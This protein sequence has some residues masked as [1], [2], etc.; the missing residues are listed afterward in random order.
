[1]DN[2]EYSIYTPPAQP[3]MLKAWRVTEGLLHAMRNEVQAHGAQFRIVTL[4]N[5]PQVM[6]DIAKRSELEQKLSVKDLDYADRRI[7]EFG[8][9]VGVPV[10]NLAPALSAYAEEHH[11]YLN[12]FTAT[13]LGSGHWN[14]TGHRLA[15]E[16]IAMDLCPGVE[17]STAVRTGAL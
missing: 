2:L 8:V 9:L 11:A 5:R 10:T 15:A 6:P 3:A 7:R 12:G 1:V 14:E 17:K 13:N 16:T 4:A